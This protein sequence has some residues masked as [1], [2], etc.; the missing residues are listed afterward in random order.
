MA[1]VLIEGLVDYARSY[2]V[3]TACNLRYRAN[4]AASTRCRD[5]LPRGWIKRRNL[6]GQPYYFDLLT[7]E[8]SWMMP[9]SRVLYGGVAPGDKDHAKLRMAVLLPSVDLQSSPECLVVDVNARAAA[10]GLKLAKTVSDVAR[11]LTGSAAIAEYCFNKIV[12]AHGWCDCLSY[13]CGDPKITGDIVINGHRRSATFNLVAALCR[14]QPTADG[15]PVMLW[16]DAICIN[17]EDTRE[18]AATIASLDVIF[19]VAPVVHMWLGSDE[20]L[21]PAL[22]ILESKLDIEDVVNDDN[23]ISDTRFLPAN[24]LARDATTTLESLYNLPYWTRKWIVQEICLARKVMLHVGRRSTASIDRGTLAVYMSRLFEYLRF[25]VHVDSLAPSC[26]AAGLMLRESGNST[27]LTEA[28][29][30]P[31]P[32]YLSMLRR[33]K[34]TMPADSVYAILSLLGNLCTLRPDYERSITSLFTEVTMQLIDACQSLDLLSQACETGSNLPSWVPDFSRPPTEFIGLRWGALEES[35]TTSRPGF[36]TQFIDE[37]RLQTLACFFDDVK[38]V[39]PAPRQD[40]VIHKYASEHVQVAMQLLAWA[41]FCAGHV[42][43]NS[44]HW[45]WKLIAHEMNR[46]RSTSPEALA[47]AEKWADDLVV[48][49]AEGRLAEVIVAMSSQLRA[50]SVDL[51]SSLFVTARGRIGFARA[52][53]GLVAGDK[54]IVL[55]TAEM[56]F[57]AAVRVHEDGDIPVII[58]KSPCNIGGLMDPSQN[59]EDGM[60]VRVVI[61]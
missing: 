7:W 35:A 17:Q 60:F 56:P 16:I 38:A 11:R 18:K 6:L 51:H 33:T 42:T 12:Y 50:L 41:S 53:V 24:G 21:E 47:N 59:F 36:S 46:G 49:T 30:Q 43:Q 28:Q 45:L 61:E 4:A 25:R 26:F 2:F 14:F 9:V 10:K 57:C 31:I 22:Q 23:L 40:T 48:A 44:M 52:D 1:S 3:A 55:A 39:A 27:S 20:S 19:A 15:K 58:L 32:F 5:G 34:A 29:R 37:G 8:W 13:C 54:V